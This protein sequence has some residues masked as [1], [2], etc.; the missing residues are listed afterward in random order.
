[1]IGLERF[2]QDENR[3]HGA[4]KRQEVDEQPGAV[5]ADQPNSPNVERLPGQRRKGDDVSYDPVASGRISAPAA[6]SAAMKGTAPSAAPRH[7]TIIRLIQWTCG[8]TLMAAV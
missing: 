5:G 3:Q 7:S 1:M 4:P 6:A 2:A 8:R